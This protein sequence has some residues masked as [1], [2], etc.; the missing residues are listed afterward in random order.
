MVLSM[1]LNNPKPKRIY[2]DNE[3]QLQVTCKRWFDLQYKN[4]SRLLF[5][6]PNGHLRNVRIAIKLKAE[7]VVARVSDMILLVP[8]KHYHALLLEFKTNKGRQTS[9]QIKFETLATQFNYKYVIIKDLKTFIDVINDYLS[10]F[11]I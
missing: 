5:A 10:N 6:V 2:N 11:E 1:K 7:G 4:L 9:E 8:N 3:H